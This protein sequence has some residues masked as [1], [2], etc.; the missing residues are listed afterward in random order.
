MPRPFIALVL[1][2]LANICA[3]AT[4]HAATGDRCSISPRETIGI[5]MGDG[6]CRGVAAGFA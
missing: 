1:N 4:T 6:Q 5:L 2:V 3:V